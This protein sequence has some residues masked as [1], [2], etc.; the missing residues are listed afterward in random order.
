MTDTAAARQHQQQPDKKLL[1]PPPPPIPNCHCYFSSDCFPGTFCYWGPGGP[2]VEDHCYWRRDKPNGTPG[3]GCNMDTDLAGGCD[4][5]CQATFLGSVLGSEDPSLLAI[6]IDLFSM[7][8][9][10]PASSGGG[11]VDPA[12]AQA[13]LGLPFKSPAAAEMLGRTVGGLFVI[14][15]GQDF[16]YPDPKLGIPP[17]HCA[18]GIALH[19][20]KDLSNEPWRLDLL[21]HLVYALQAELAGDIRASNAAMEGA[22]ACCPEPETAFAPVCTG[23]SA[24]AC[25]LARIRDQAIVLTTPRSTD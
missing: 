10:A 8:F 24:I 3:A 20:V 13:A 12:I 16:F 14:G 21:K 25:V 7:S 4:G 9:L 2:F 19:H 11:A 18:P 6:G 22:L 5:I 15:A 23:P 17:G 1:N